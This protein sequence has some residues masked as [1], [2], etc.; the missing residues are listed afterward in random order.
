MEYRKLGRTGLDVSAISLGLEYLHNQPRETVISTVREAIAGG[1][2]YFDVIFSFPDYLDNLGAAF[3]GHREKVI[4]TAHL[5]STEKNGQYAKSR[6]L[7]KSEAAFLALLDR[8][9]TDYID[10]LFLHNCDTQKDYERLIKPNGILELALRLRDQGKARYIG[11]SGH[12]VA[13]ATQA[14]ETG[15]VDVLMFPVNLPSNAVEGKR[16]LL[17]ACAARG[18]AVVA[19]K[20]FGGG[21]LLQENR[22]VQLASYQAGGESMKVKKTAPITPVQCLAYVL[23]QPGVSTAVPGCKSAEEVSAALGWLTATEAEKDFSEILAGFEQFVSGE[24]TYCNHCLPCPSKIDIGQTM[25]LLDMA[26]EELTAQIRATYNQMSTHASDCSECN[27]C[28]ERCP[29]GVD[30][31]PK[32]KETVAVFGG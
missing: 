9:N 14:I 29:F 13:T 24:C 1:M 11:F 23:S 15:H 25:R 12:T 30:V 6:A 18:V 22:T 8:L 10:V 3:A 7:K 4:L 19:M 32:M 28:T 2:N 16:E 21:K 20:P 26:R 5:G 27:A 31:V 17:N